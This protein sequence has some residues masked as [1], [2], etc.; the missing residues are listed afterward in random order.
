M[1]T[2]T[3]NTA[4][5]GLRL[6]IWLASKLDMTRSQLQKL[7]KEGL[8]EVNDQP[9]RTNY[10]LLPDDVVTVK[11]RP[12]STV[13][14]TPPDLPI[15][16]QDADILVVDKP[17]GI[18]VHLGNGMDMEP[19][20]ADFARLHTEDPDEERPGIVHRLDRETSGLLVIAKTLA[21]KD[22]LQRLWQERGVKKTYLLLAVG[23][24]EPAAAI[25]SL[26]LGRDPGR[27]LRRAV[28]PGGKAAVTRYKTL[29]AYPGYTLIEAAPETGRTH[30]LR[31]HFASIGHSVAGDIVYGPLTRLL[32]LK[33]QFLHAAKLEFDLPSG[34]R[35][36]LESPL[37]A[38]LKAALAKLEPAK[39]QP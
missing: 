3:A 29:A 12:A 23:R 15:V 11:D 4:A 7:V 30:Q 6:D 1:R 14:V 37:P 9:V 31:V 18:A 22:Y 39:L 5:T 26:P 20:V 13:E 16:Y 36:K 2:F 34:R 19:T 38:E 33:R 27:P 28:V 21:A 24:V 25:I 8:V 32:G 35:L 10:I 17:A